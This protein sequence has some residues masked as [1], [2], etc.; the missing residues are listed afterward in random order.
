MANTTGDR[1]WFWTM[2]D[3]KSRIEGVGLD[4][5][6]GLQKIDSSDVRPMTDAAIAFV[7]EELARHPGSRPHRFARGVLLAELE[8]RN[9]ERHRHQVRLAWATLFFAFISAVVG[10]IALVKLA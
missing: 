2:I 4:R 8:R 7:L 1:G 9:G 5:N 3:E 6:R 10:T